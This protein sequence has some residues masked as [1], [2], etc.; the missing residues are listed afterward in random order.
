VTSDN[1]F[2]GLAA[3]YQQSRPDYPDDL[4]AHLPR[5][6]AGAPDAP[7]I[8][9]DIGAGT[10]IATRAFRR[11]L[12]PDWAITGVEPGPD[13]RRQAA[14]ATPAE[15]A[16]NYVEGDAE[17]LPAEEA[18]VG[19]V[20]VAQAI[21]F[22][23]R[24]VFYAEAA[25]VLHV[26]G[27]LGI[28]QNNRDWRASALLDAYETYSETHSEGYSRTYRDIDVLGELADL[29]WADQAE[30]F[31]VVWTMPMTPDRFVAMTLSRR[32]MKPAVA[33]LG[34]ARVE[35]D[36]TALAG[37]HTDASGHVQIPY[38]SELFVVVKQ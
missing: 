6:V 5:L 4:L 37:A 25:R 24:P 22:F 7:R 1:P 34:E 27:V 21:Q 15:D 23:D 16:I 11:A 2:E 12:G 20:T 32:T 9:M 30:R 19:V 28:L 14:A 3:R 35:A 29:A 31:E 18:S 26:G 8:L 17:S 10:G 38:V 36:L 13:M 33:A